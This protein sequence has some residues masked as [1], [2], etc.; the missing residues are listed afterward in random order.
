MECKID[1]DAIIAIMA[2]LV[3]IIISAVSAA[4]EAHIRF[5]D[6]F[7]TFYQKTF[8]LRNELS[9]ILKKNSTEEF[10]YEIDRI[11]HCEDVKDK[12]L[13]YLTETEDFLFL[14]VGHRSVYRSFEKLM[15]PALYR[16]L[17]MFYGFIIRLRQECNNQKLFLNYEKALMRIK[18]MKKIRNQNSNLKN[19]CYI[20]IRSSDRMY[21]SGYF[22]KDITIFSN[23]VGDKDFPIRPNQNKFNKYV[24]PYITERI[25]VLIAQNDSFRFMFYNSAM[26]YMLPLELQKYFICLNPRE[27]ITIFNNKPE[28]KRWF[29]HHS[30]P[31]IPYETFLVQEITLETLHKHFPLTERYVIQSSH[32]GGG[33]GTFLVSRDNFESIS[34]ILQPF[35]QYLVSPYIEKS[36]SVNT[37]VF[38]AD[39]Q[40]ILSPGSVQ[41]VECE[42]NQLC[43]RGADFIAFRTLSDHCRDQVRELSLKIGNHLRETGYHGI[44]GLDFIVTNDEKIF[45]VEINPRFQ[46][47]TILLDLF[48][49]KHTAGSNMAHSVFELNEQAFNNQMFSTLC[50]DDVV[51][52]SCYYYYKGTISVNDL[53]VKRSILSDEHV[54]IHDDGIFNFTKEG[55]L[56]Q[57]SYAFRAVFSHPICAISPDMTLWLND[58]IPT[59]LAPK[60]SIELK[61]A[62]LNQGVRISGNAKHIKEGTYESIDIIYHGLA[63]QQQKPLAMNC[64]Y[65]VNLSK[66]SPFVIEIGG[67]ACLEYDELTYYGKLLGYVNVEI[68]RL[69]DFSETDRRILY[70]ATDRLRIK[71]ISGCEYKNAGI[72]CAFCNLRASDKRF[73]RKEL[74]GALLRLKANKIPFRHILIGGGTCLAPDIWEDVIWLCQYL[75]SDDYYKGKTISLMSILPPIEILSSLH[76]AGLEEVA[77]NL[78]V[79]NDKLARTLMPGKRNR[80]KSAYYS[81]LKEAVKIFGIGAVRSALL[82]GF[83][84]E[85]ELI[86]EVRY[87]ANMGIIPCLSS[88]RAL[89]GSE[90]A[91]YIHPDNVTLRK[92][93]DKCSYCLANSGGPICELGPKCPMCRNNM[94]AI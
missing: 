31:T 47:S 67:D 66:Y 84:K 27:L 77:F 90:L 40:T 41:I 72:G 18:H 61:I 58:N 46:A 94:L 76:N 19:K 21:D 36:I 52:Y 70:M 78:E 48:L 73:T 14:V 55:F 23:E 54:I 32:G 91:D 37:H 9:T 93:Y 5:I 49:E 83:D 56:D 65:G 17:S 2:L 16:R 30:L 33:I 24:L 1:M 10:Y 92:I 53:M 43:Y 26:A 7:N 3:T 29:A 39:K 79:S 59:R 86:D 63:P 81:T 15:S 64:A 34:S 80:T 4:R 44:A 28:L 88:F 62:L 6:K 20:G 57:D 35:R 11:W 13:D 87:L 75:K 25:K 42:E 60:D 74:Q 50:F 8:A 89:N 22:R 45:C 85:D 68:D 12:V 69:A 82:V 38:V 51:N 71:L